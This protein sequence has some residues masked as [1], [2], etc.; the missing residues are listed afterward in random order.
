MEIIRSI[1]NSK[2]YSEDWGKRVVEEFLEKYSR[3]AYYLCQQTGIKNW[4]LYRV[5]VHAVCHQ[6]TRWEIVKRMVK[7]LD[8]YEADMEFP[9]MRAL[10]L[11]FVKDVYTSVWASEEELRCVLRILEEFGGQIVS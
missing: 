9:E 7:H 2:H 4:Q 10:Y 1:P 5:M 6:Q 8:Q 11:T 3:G